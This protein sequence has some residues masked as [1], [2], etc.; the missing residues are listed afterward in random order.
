[1]VPEDE[2]KI[3]LDML[4]AQKIDAREAAE[5]LRALRGARQGAAK[6]EEPSDREEGEQVVIKHVHLGEGA[7]GRAEGTRGP[8]AVVDVGNIG[9]AIGSAVARAVGAIGDTDFGDLVGHTV[10]IGRRRRRVAPGPERA[11]RTFTSELDSTGCTRLEIRNDWGSLTIQGTYE[12]VIALEGRAVGYGHTPSEAEELAGSVQVKIEREDDTA[13]A[14]ITA[15]DETEGALTVDVTIKVPRGLHV[16]AAAPQGSIQASGLSAGLSARTVWASVEAKDCTGMVECK[17]VSGSLH[18]SGC[19]GPLTARTTSASVHVT[20]QRGEMTVKSVSGSL[21]IENCEGPLTAS[22]VSAST[23]VANHRGNLV[24][25]SVSGGVQ[26]GIVQ[27]EKVEV[28]TTSGRV[29]VAV[30][31]PFS[32][33][34]DAHSVSGGVELSLHPESSVRLRVSTTSGAVENEFAPAREPTVR[35]G[36]GTGNVQVRTVSGRI[37]VRKGGID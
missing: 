6:E 23:Y 29:Q 15:E 28:G 1:M 32:G 21:H 26:A 27:A 5:L 18:A 11:E 10:S 37:E 14:T 19:Q 30:R 24:A 9:R 17:S 22:T 4:Q 2:I 31:E 13:E 33:E 12:N 36:E 7:R 25:K 16:R 20:D 35:L 3:I 8:R 34:L